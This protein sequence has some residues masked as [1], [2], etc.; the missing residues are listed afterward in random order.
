M[1]YKPRKIKSLETLQH[2]SN[3]KSLLDSDSEDEEHQQSET[4]TKDKKSNDT[5]AIITL[6]S[7]YS[8][9]PLRLTDA[10]ALQ[11][12]L[13]DPELPLHFPDD[14]YPQ[15][16]SLWAAY[17]WIE[18]V[19]DEDGRYMPR[20]YMVPDGGEE[21]R[22]RLAKEIYQRGDAATKRSILDARWDRLEEDALKTAA[23]RQEAEAKEKE[24]EKK[25][26]RAK[27]AAKT[28]APTEQDEE[29]KETA[30]EESNPE[31]PERIPTSFAIASPSDEVVGLIDLTMVD[32]P[33]PP[34]SP[35]YENA[36]EVL[37]TTFMHAAELCY[38]LSPDHRGKSLMST[39]VPKFVDWAW[40]HFAQLEDIGAATYS[41]WSQS[42]S[43][44]L[45][46]SGFLSEGVRERGVYRGGQIGRMESWAIGR[47][48]GSVEKLRLERER[49]EKKQWKDE[50]ATSR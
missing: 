12:V 4:K 47:P 5:T 9:R 22:L 35:D 28:S 41:D 3:R 14:V 46:K 1:P 20:R 42:S 43:R 7:G 49:A 15:P 32:P 19:I 31:R 25:K 8:V 6:P 29:T 21:A 48:E 38:V 16:F 40:Q 45:I 2:S 13:N 26:R 36:T 11:T 17:K 44:V 33:F 39:I 34:S 24:K 37:D 10:P 23:D 30:D 27:G 50:V 18:S